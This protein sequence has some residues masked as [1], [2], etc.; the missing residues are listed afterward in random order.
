LK[1]YEVRFLAGAIDDLDALFVYIARRSS[2]EIADSYLARIERSCLS[3]QSLPV[4]GT[5]VTGDVSGLRTMGF[6][7]RVTILF[8]VGVDR[9][10]ILRVLYGGRDLEPSVEEFPE[11]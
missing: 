8:R 6:E 7:C 2:L 10:D 3:L 5:A 9:V 1:R 11:Q 4:R